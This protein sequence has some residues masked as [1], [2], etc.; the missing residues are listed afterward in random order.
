VAATHVLDDQDD[1][2]PDFR[3]FSILYEENCEF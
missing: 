3:G 1:N 2:T